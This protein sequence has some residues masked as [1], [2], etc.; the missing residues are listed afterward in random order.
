MEGWTKGKGQLVE[1]RTSD[2]KIVGLSPAN[3][4]P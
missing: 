3:R 1:L 4:E 2:Q